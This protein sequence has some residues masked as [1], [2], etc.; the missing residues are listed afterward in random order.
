MSVPS[1]TQL[2]PTPAAQHPFLQHPELPKSGQSKSLLSSH[3]SLSLS[4]KAAHPENHSA[5]QPHPRVKLL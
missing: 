2:P 5:K 1:S 4:Q 3:L